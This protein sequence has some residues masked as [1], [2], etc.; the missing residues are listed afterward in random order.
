MTFLLSIDAG[1]SG[2]RAALF[3]ERGAFVPGAQSH[4]HRAFTSV[5]DFAEFDADQI[6]AEVVATIDE[7]VA[8][9]TGRIE[10]IAISAFW[11]SLIGVDDAGLQTTPLLTWA[12]TRAAQFVN[13]LRANFDEREI[14]ARTGC[15]FHPSYWPAKLQWLEHE[16]PEQFQRTRWWLGVAEYLCLRLFGDSTMSVSMASA[17]GLF[18]QRACNWDTD[19]VKALGFS[20]ETLPGIK[21]RIDSRLSATYAS[22]WPAL[23]E[24]RLVIVVGDGA[25]NNV[26]AGCSTKD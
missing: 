17:T 1:T 5:S 25:A 11:H 14:H 4:N 6:V 15:R 12:D 2:V 19:F 3:D 8:N 18:N 13:T 24:A 7:L 26:G 9:F 23:K 21:P 10:L 22:R 16:R 20:D